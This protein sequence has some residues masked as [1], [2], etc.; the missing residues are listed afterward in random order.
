[1]QEGEMADGDQQGPKTEGVLGSVLAFAFLVSACL[2]WELIL[3]AFTEGWSG[4]MPIMSGSCGFWLLLIGVGLALLFHI[5]GN[6][7]KGR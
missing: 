6:D 3:G 4:P 2:L 5:A 1:M 7:R